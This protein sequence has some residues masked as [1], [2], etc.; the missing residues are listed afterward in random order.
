M[1]APEI[2]DAMKDAGASIEVILAALR[3]DAALA[4]KAVE[5][6][7][8]KD[9]E[10]QARHRLSRKV[11]VTPRDSRDPSPKD[12][13]QTPI[14]VLPTK[15]SGLEPK[16]A[17]LRKIA[18]PID[19][20]P[21]PIKPEG[22]AGRIIAAWPAGRMERE[23]SKFKDHALANGVRHDNWQAAWRNWIIKAD[24]FDGRFTQKQTGPTSIGRNLEAASL[25]FGHPST[26]SDDR[27]F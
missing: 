17:K 15:P 4:D 26:W 10:R 11:T 2:L 27:S 22:H 21:E 13:T 5:E 9:R 16:R 7:R 3:A 6:R 1:I 23:L 12:N 24:E 8:A 25:A 20:Q 18:L 14:P 19:W